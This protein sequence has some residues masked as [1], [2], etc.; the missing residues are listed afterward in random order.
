MRDSK[1][2]LSDLENAGGQAAVLADEFNWWLADLWHGKRL[3]YSLAVLAV[4]AAL[5]F[6]VA[7]SRQPKQS[8]S[9]WRSERRR[10]IT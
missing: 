7:A 10:C 3:A 2:Y 5:A 6:F 9:S 1:Q 8:S 4:A